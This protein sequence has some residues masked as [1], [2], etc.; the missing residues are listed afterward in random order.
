MLPASF[1]A[2]VIEDVLEGATAWDAAV[3]AGVSARVLTDWL[4]EAGVMLRTGRP[5]PDQLSSVVRPPPAKSFGAPAGHG[6]RLQLADRIWIEMGI[7]QGDDPDRIASSLGVHRSTVFRELSR[8]SLIAHD[9]RW[10]RDDAHYSAALAQLWADEARVR[11][12]AFKLETLPLLRRMVIDM[13]NHKISPQQI[14]VRL[15]REFPDD[16]NMQISHETLYQT[17]YVQGA[18]ALR[19]ELKVEGA[20]RSG[21]KTRK[22]AS[23]LPPRSNRSWLEGHRLADRDDITAAEHAG[24]K[25][26]GHWEGD[27]VVGPNNSGIIT[28]VERASRFTLLGRLPGTRDSTTVIDMLAEMVED[29]PGAVQRSITWDQG[30]EMAQH[31]RFTVETGCP[32]FF[33]DP[34]SPWQRPTNENLNG[35]LRWEYPKGTDFNL[36]TDAELEAV[37][38]MLNARPRVILEGATP[39]ET[40][41]E[42]ITT[43]ALTN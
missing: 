9:G 7:A 18:G 36:V 43:V 37:Q 1:R 35:Q 10:N 24:R 20:I 5:S 41:D 15:R 14:S 39:S 31:A 28:L 30:M 40:L 23:K 16:E 38:D 8:H 42:L 4:R 21:R 22:P 33:C 19:H 29:L 34:H 13:L 2:G 11:P 17:L 12:K 3:A 6:R 26:P 32:V 25:I 27:L